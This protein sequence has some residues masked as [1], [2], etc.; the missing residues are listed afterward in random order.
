MANH[1]LPYRTTLVNFHLPVQIAERLDE[2]AKRQHKP[3]V[4]LAIEAFSQYF[5]MNVRERVN[6][7]E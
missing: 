1:K 2:E 3:K 5:N 7:S 6:G 4:K